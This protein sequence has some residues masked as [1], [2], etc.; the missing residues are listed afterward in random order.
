MT[1]VFGTQDGVIPLGYDFA[2]VYQRKAPNTLYRPFLVAKL[3][4]SEDSLANNFQRAT[5]FLVKK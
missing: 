4:I 5:S 2:D 3:Q 1:P